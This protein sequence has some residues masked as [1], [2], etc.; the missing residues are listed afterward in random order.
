M[1]DVETLE[2]DAFLRQ[3][4]PFNAL[5]DAALATI[6][7]ALTI[8]YA[9][10]GTEILAAGVKNE[11][12]FIV[13][14]GAVELLEGGANLALMVS[15]GGC[16]AFPS[17]LRDGITRHGV[18]AIE[19]TLLYCVPADVFH[20]LCDSHRDFRIYF[21]SEEAA[22]LRAA[23]AQR[24]EASGS[25]GPLQSAG[26]L[27]SNIIAKRPLV[28]G[29][30]DMTSGD[31]AALMAQED[32]ST[33]LILDGDALCGIV[34]DKDF[35]R[36]LIAKGLPYDT[37]VSE[38]M[39]P[40]PVT[41][42]EALAGFEALLLMTRHNFSHLPVTNVSGDLVGLVSARDLLKRMSMHA[43]HLAQDVAKATA[44]EA[45]CEAV[46]P[47]GRSLVALVEADLTAHVIGEFVSSVAEAAHRRL[48][49]LGEE[50]F[51][52]PPVPYDFVVFGSLARRD[53]SG[54]S[55]QDNGFII[56]DAYIEAEHGAYFES[57]A[58]F[59]SDGLNAAGYV[60]CPGD[61]MATNPALRQSLSGWRKKFSGWINSPDP[62]SV[63]HTT[64]FYDMRCVYGAGKLTNDLRKSVIV[65]AQDNKLFLAHLAKDALSAT[66]PLGF[67]RQ[68]VVEKDK[69][70]EESLNMKQRGIMPIVD[71]A[72]LKALANNLS[73]VNTRSRLE[74]LEAADAL[75]EG[76][77]RDLL[78]AQ[79]FI[80]MTRLRHQARQVSQGEKVDNLVHIADLS[81][82][83][84]DHLKDAFVIVRRQQ[85]AIA[86]SYTGGV[87]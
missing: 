53:Q 84:R 51:G 31:A 37:L 86:L 5:D 11:H 59:I 36:R 62:K 58:K 38:I 60:Y 71:I 19:D 15:A 81:R 87:L 12:L 16:F 76:D 52:P 70:G 28:T 44:P 27:L 80:A 26:T 35:R 47:L 41:I 43:A 25:L 63:M 33:L 40:N 14:S 54:I 34:T 21:S 67:F 77:A 24:A 6:T 10:R 78:D 50:Q 72:R 32:V 39:S 48:A 57:L 49:E 82:F 55:D 45:V 68:L 13:R 42:A 20:Q 23:I 83:E 22:R 17:L 46:K 7:G 8:R 30:S 4:P 69:S 74:A 1:P 18:K 66:P 73:Q 85:S 2:I 75:N 61:I 64:I 79:E 3:H 29:A 56:D 65:Q 9:R